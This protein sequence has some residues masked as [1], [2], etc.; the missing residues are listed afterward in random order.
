MRTIKESKVM[1]ALEEMRAQRAREMKGLS[2]EARVRIYNE[3]GEKAAKKM[4]LSLPVQEPV[5][6]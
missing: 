2:V 4:G 1:V 5:K 3:E 6:I